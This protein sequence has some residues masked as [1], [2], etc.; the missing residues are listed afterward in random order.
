MDTSKISDVNLNNY[1]GFDSLYD[2]VDEYGWELKNK[3]FDY[4]N[5]LME[6][7][8]SKYLQKNPTMKSFFPYLNKMMSHL[9]NS[10]KYLRNF[11]NWAVKKDY[12]YIN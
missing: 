1:K 12:K 9:I 2:Y 8:T 10:V 6:V 3:G 5:N 7:S 11:N 4:E